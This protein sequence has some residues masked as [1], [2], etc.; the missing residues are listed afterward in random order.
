MNMNNDKWKFVKDFT[1]SNFKKII[2]KLKQTHEF[3]FYKKN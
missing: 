2:T 1:E 3:I